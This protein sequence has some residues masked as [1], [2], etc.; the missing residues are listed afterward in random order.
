MS[1]LIIDLIRFVISLVEKS[2]TGDKHS[3][4][5]LID[6]IPEDLK[7]ELVAKVQ[8]ELDRKKFGPRKVIQ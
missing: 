6:F 5:K 4:Q 3:L 2:C 1:Q 8:D 7:T